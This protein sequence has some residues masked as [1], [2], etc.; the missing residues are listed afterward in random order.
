MKKDVL[1]S[2]PS[3]YRDT[4]CVMGYRFGKGEKSCAIV[5]AMRGNEVQQL[6]VC[7]RL[8]AMLRE[9]EEDGGIVPGKSVMVIPTINNFSMNLSK[10]FWSMD[11]TDINRVFPGQPDGETTQRIA[12]EVFE[13][14]K[15]YHYGMQLASFYMPGSFIPHVRLMEATDQ[16]IEL[17]K[18]F[19]FPYVYLRMPK[20][21]DENTL[22]YNWRKA[23][24][25]AFSLYAGKTEAI[26]EQAAEACLRSILRFLNQRGIV[27]FDAPPG[28]SSA[29]IT[30]EDIHAVYST[31]AG[32]LRRIKFAG[33][34]VR[35]GEQLAF[36]MDPYDG[37]VREVL[38][39]P[40]TGTIFF[41][42]NQPFAMEHTPIYKVLGS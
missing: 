9:I 27:K 21:Y 31:S 18:D 12:Y 26:D 13:R 42:H 34:H 33:A 28:H 36:I 16:G 30:D 24:A 39:T 1:F 32:L 23:G 2:L 40:V 29:V 14:L 20:L 4:M 19:G 11:N 22:S 41:V 25:Q 17:A 6:Y 15:H 10:R 7:S 3:P 37:S 35:R 5:G 38:R 8:V